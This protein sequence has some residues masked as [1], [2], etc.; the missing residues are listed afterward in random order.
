MSKGFDLIQW[1]YIVA[2]ASTSRTGSSYPSFPLM[3]PCIRHIASS[4]SSVIYPGPQP[5]GPPPGIVMH[6]FIISSL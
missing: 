2:M 3:S 6:L 1:A 5:K 4:L